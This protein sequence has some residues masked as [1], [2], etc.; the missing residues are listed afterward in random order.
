MATKVCCN[1]GATCGIG[2]EI[3]TAPLVDGNQVAA[4]C[5]KPEALT[6]APRFSDDLLAVTLDVTRKDQVE[7]GAPV[8][9]IAVVFTVGGPVVYE[10]GRY[11]LT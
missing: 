7:M 5:R 8:P 11:Q 10:R 6:K 4:T 1:N 3:V 9:I 2:A